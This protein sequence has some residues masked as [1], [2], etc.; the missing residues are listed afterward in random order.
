MD[1]TY[2]SNW[3]GLQEIS[4]DIAQKRADIM[5][6]LDDLFTTIN[7]FDPS[8]WAGSPYEAFKEEC[9]KKRADAVDGSGGLN[10]QLG[11]EAEKFHSLSEE[12]HATEEQATNLWG[13]Q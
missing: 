5:R 8:K 13:G 11:K 4:D 10:E 1:G 6:D 7:K 12:A 2:V 3:E 9:N